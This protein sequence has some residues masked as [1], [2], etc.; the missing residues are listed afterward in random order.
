M[1]LS[2]NNLLV[3]IG[4]KNLHL[5]GF[6][7]TQFKVCFWLVEFKDFFY[8]LSLRIIMFIY[9]PHCIENTIMNKMQ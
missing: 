8:K 1:D 2:R 6:F 9:C 5:R 3:I 4:N 7:C